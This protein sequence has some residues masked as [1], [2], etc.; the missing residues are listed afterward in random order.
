MRNYP[1][2]LNSRADYEYVRAHFPYKMW[3]KDY[4][5]LIADEYRWF[6][7]GQYDTADGLTVDATHKVDESKTGTGDDA[8]TVY[9]YSEYRADEN[10][11]MYRL[12]YTREEIEKYLSEGNA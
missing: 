5:R 7:I 10:C 11:K 6:P 2:H 1:K 8:K 9:L 4:K 12:G 3:A